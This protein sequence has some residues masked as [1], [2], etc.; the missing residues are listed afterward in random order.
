MWIAIPVAMDIWR[1][2]GSNVAIRRRALGW[3]QE[4][5]AVKAGFSQQYLSGIENGRR[6]P[7][8]KTIDELARALDVKIVD[9]FAEIGPIGEATPPTRK[10]GPKSKGK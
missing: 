5:F 2:V 4:L 10:P 7:T 8:L 6:N 3:S 9:L 1:L